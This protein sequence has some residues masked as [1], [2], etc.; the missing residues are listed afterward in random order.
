MAWKPPRCSGAVW[1]IGISVGQTASHAACSE[2]AP[3]P[4]TSIRAVICATR[5]ARS[6]CPWG[7]RASCEIFAPV[8]S[9]AD[10]FGH[11][12]THAPQPMQAAASIASSAR[13]FGTAIALPSGAP[14]TSS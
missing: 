6:G 9:D 7:S 10:A 13:S 12:A 1:A 3:K 2:Q 8:K 4:S 14:P 11:A 5:R